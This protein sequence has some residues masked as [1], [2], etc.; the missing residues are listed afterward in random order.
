VLFLK[1]RHSFNNY[2]VDLRNVSHMELPIL[3]ARETS[4]RYTR[5]EMKS[6]MQP[7]I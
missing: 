4:K 7:K 3:T 2:F 6:V 1:E 5:W